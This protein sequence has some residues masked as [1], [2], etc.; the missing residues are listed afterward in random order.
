MSN[1]PFFMVPDELKNLLAQISS[2]DVDD[3]IIN[4]AP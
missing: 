1:D 4:D 2:E 3:T